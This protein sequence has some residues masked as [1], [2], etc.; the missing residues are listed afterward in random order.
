MRWC[1]LSA[2]VLS[3]GG[4][5]G[6]VAKVGKLECIEVN[7]AN[8]PENVVEFHFDKQG[9][10]TVTV[11]RYP[12]GERGERRMNWGS[13]EIQEA[14]FRKSAPIASRVIKLG[15]HGEV[16][17]V[18]VEYGAGYTLAWDGVFS[19]AAPRLALA[20]PFLQWLPALIPLRTTDRNH[21]T[22]GAV[23]NFTGTVTATGDK[24]FVAE[25]LDGRLLSLSTDDEG[26]PRSFEWSG[27]DLVRAT[28]S[29]FTAEISSKKGKILGVVQQFT[30]QDGGRRVLT[31]EYKR[32]LL[33]RVK[34]TLDVGEKSETVWDMQIRACTR[35]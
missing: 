32:G 24:K 4:C 21:L 1:V 8:D 29:I 19:D 26:A 10:H 30:D 27:D 28:G 15:P 9:R 2:V 11:N 33:V 20:T 35:R 14:D 12:D 23:F 5:G 25:Y 22:R 31:M 34:E 16:V 3:L 17:H 18:S 13:K 7:H 6:S